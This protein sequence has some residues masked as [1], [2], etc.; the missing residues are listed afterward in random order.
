MTLIER[1]SKLVLISVGLFSAGVAF[2]LA[3]RILKGRFKY[4]L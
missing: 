4:E 2:K 3:R 1:M